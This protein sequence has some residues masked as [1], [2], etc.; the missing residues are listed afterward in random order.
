MRNDRTVCLHREKGGMTAVCDGLV[1]VWFVLCLP[2][3][4]RG[5]VRGQ[6]WS[7]ANEFTKSFPEMCRK[8]GSPVGENVDRKSVEP[9]NVE[10][11]QLSSYLS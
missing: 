8:L 10:D 6:S 1:T 3:G 4:L 2:I 11:E 9:R 7:S 5:L